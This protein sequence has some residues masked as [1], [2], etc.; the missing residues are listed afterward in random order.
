MKKIFTLMTFVCTSMIAT[1][2]FAQNVSKT[3]ETQSDYADLINECWKF[4]TVDHSPQSPL[5]G[6]GSLISQANSLSQITTP[7]LNMGSSVTISFMYQREQIAT[8][9]SK[10]LKIYLMD[11][12]GN[13][14]AIETITLNDDN[15]N[16]FSQTYTNANTPGNHLPN[17][18]RSL[19]SWQSLRPMTTR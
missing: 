2:S 10:T 3:F 15:L 11:S 1:N 12:L 16:S 18:L 7:F 6:I 14:T 19:P 4:T 13:R 5:D 17:T 9:G 8:G